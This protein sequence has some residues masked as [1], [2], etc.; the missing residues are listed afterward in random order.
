VELLTEIVE[1]GPCDHGTALFLYWEAVSSR[2]PDTG[3][4]EEDEAAAYVEAW[5][6]RVGAFA[7]RLAGRL[8]AGAFP[9]RTIAYDPAKDRTPETLALGDPEL[10]RPS[11]GEPFDEFAG[12][13]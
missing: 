1:P 2:D 12:Q 3:E 9:C 13:P 4:A 11:P 6:S 10:V 7:R 8:K 5:R